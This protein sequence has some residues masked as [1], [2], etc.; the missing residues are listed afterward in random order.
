MLNALIRLSL[1]YRFLVVVIS[2]SLLVYGSY[3]ATTM[4]ID[5]FPDLDRPRV[6]LLTECPGLSTE[7]VETLVTQPIEIALLGASGVEAV[8]SQSTAGLNVIYIEFGWE[9]KTNEARQTVQERLST[10][11]GELPQGIHPEMTPRSSIMGQIVIA[12]MY[13][14]QGPSGGQLAAI[15]QTP[16]MAELTDD[17]NVAVWQPRDRHQVS[18]WEP[19]NVSG[20]ALAAGSSLEENGSPNV[21]PSADEPASSREFDIRIEGS[22]YR[23]VFPS[24]MQQ[25]L[26]LGT[27]GDWVVRPRLLKVSGVAEC[28]LQGSERKQYQILVDPNALIEYGVTLQDVQRVI[29]ESNINTSGGFAITGES[30]RPIRIL[31][32]I[33]PD[34]KQVIEDLQKVPVRVTEK[35][36]I[37]LS[38]VATIVEGA[39]FKRGDGAVNGHSGLVFTVVKQPHFDTRALTDDVASALAEVERSLPA[40]IVINSELFRLRNFIDRGVFNVGEALAIGALLVIVVLFLFLLNF[41]TTFITLAAIPLSLVITTL[42]LG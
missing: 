18:T 30:E 39:E 21:S 38:Q 13:R 11:S 17:G 27:L 33:G 36:S 15:K 20:K 14:Q 10:I 24:E 28:F 34:A 42:V 25:E 40:D 31:G 9:T 19:I 4:P 16:W 22:D 5:A 32:R 29:T 8:R 2:L 35:R 3:L 7:E 12:G 37:L 1:R 26:E 23:V 6:I 41:R